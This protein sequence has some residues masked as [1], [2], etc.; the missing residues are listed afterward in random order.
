MKNIISI[1]S[2]FYFLTC[3]VPIVMS[4]AQDKVSDPARQARA[5]EF[6]REFSSITQDS[7]YPQIY[8]ALLNSL[9]KLPE[10]VFTKVTD[11]AHPLI[12]VYT[13][14][15]GIARYAHATEFT[16]QE[17]D[18]PAFMDGFYLIQLADEL[19]N[20]Q[21]VESIEGIILHE[22]AHAY[23]EHLRKAVHSCEMEKEANQLVISW[24]YDEEYRK[25]VE[26]FG[27]KKPGD[28]PCKGDN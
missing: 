12:F 28:S 5:E 3:P 14:N 18:L 10:D 27:A 6:L 9:A 22:I 2:I 11:R 17:G 21:D 23:L 15:T 24:G 4:E 19:N 13:I 1:L 20:M 26:A 25:A 16:F 7:I 8:Q